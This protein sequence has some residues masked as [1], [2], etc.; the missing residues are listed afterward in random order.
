MRFLRGQR[1][2]VDSV[3]RLDDRQSRGEDIFGLFFEVPPWSPD[4]DAFGIPPCATL[5]DFGFRGI[6]TLELAN[7]FGTHY[8]RST[9]STVST[10][11]FA[12]STRP[13][14]AIHWINDSS[15]PVG[16]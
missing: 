13:V 9:L 12:D 1:G 5:A 10:Y 7:T 6:D 11:E 8:F 15:R 14:V 16:D 4:F 2:V 3:E